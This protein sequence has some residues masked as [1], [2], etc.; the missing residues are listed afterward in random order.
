MLQT[1]LILKRKKERQSLKSSLYFPLSLY[2]KKKEKKQILIIRH[3]YKNKENIISIIF[4][5]HLDRE[6]EKTK[7]EE[8]HSLR[9]SLFKTQEER[10]RRGGDQQERYTP[11]PSNPSLSLRAWLLLPLLKDTHKETLVE[12]EGHTQRQ[13]KEEKVWLGV[14][15]KIY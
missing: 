11:S 14:W 3:F 8:R 15:S 7:E 10:G 2:I 4:S 12:Q 5:P 6:G 13:L 1:N 9:D